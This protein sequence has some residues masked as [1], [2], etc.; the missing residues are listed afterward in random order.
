MPITDRHTVKQPTANRTG[1]LLFNHN[2]SNSS[3]QCSSQYIHIHISYLSPSTYFSRTHFVLH[4]Y[5]KSI[6]Q[7]KPRKKY[8]PPDLSSGSSLYGKSFKF[9]IKHMYASGRSPVVMLYV[10]V[11][12][13]VYPM[14]KFIFCIAW[15]TIAL[16]GWL[17][18]WIAFNLT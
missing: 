11:N 15:T 2:Y 18:Y 9:I 16:S 5:Y 14:W 7:N 6:K 10:I 3:V 13:C 12:R 4:S 8:L 17:G 1:Q